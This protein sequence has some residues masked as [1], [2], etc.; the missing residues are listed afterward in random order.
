MGAR[1]CSASRP[2][3]PMARVH[4]TAPPPPSR[5]SGD[6]CRQKNLF[7]QI[8]GQLLDTVFDYN[9]AGGASWF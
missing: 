1:V 8:D 6:K 5:P 4:T 7:S 3:S 9:R 2:E